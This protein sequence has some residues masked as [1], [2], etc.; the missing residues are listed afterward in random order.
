V[1]CFATDC[2][3]ERSRRAGDEKPTLSAPQPSTEPTGFTHEPKG[4]QLMFDLSKPA[5]PVVAYLHEHGPRIELFAP[6]FSLALWRLVSDLED[7]D[8]DDE[9]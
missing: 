1:I 5:Q 6:S 8:L 9:E 3:R 7:E 2:S 4:D